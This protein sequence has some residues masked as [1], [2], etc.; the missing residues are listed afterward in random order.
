ML[1]VLLLQLNIVL[2]IQVEL[3]LLVLFPRV[4]N[5]SFIFME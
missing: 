3:T 4:D 2:S 5:F 1:I